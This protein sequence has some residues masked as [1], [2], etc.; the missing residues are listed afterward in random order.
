MTLPDSIKKAP[1]NWYNLD[2][3]K[4]GVIGVSTEKAYNELLRGKKPSKV[5][6]AIIDSGIETDHEDLKGSIWTNSDEIPANGIDDDN[7]G[8][9]DDINGWDFIGGPDSTFVEQDTWE[10]TRQYVIFSNKYELKDGESLINKDL[11]DWDYFQT[12]KTDYD[13]QYAENKDSYDNIVFLRDKINSSEAILKAYL[14]TDTVLTEDLLN[15]KTEVD[16]VEE[17]CVFLK[18]TRN[19]GINVSHLEGG[20]KYYETNLK[21]KLNK[22]F[23]PRHIVGDDYDDLTSHHYGNNLVEGPDAFHGTHVSGIVCADRENGIGIKGIADA[24][25]LM[26]LRVVPSGDERDKDVA[27]AVFY[28]VDNGAKIINMSFGKDYS[29]YK[30]YVDSAFR[31]ADAHGVLVIHAAGNDSK[32]SD[33]SPSYPTKKYLD[34]KGVCNNWIEVGAIH[35]KDGNNMAAGFTNYGKNTVDLFAPGVEIYSTMPNQGY[36]NASG[37][38]MAAPVVTGVAALVLSYHPNL[39][40]AEL[41]KVL[42]DSA[43]SY[44]RQKVKKPGNP[45]ELVRFAKLSKTGSVVNA[46]TALKAADKFK[47]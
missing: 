31:Y 25:E 19:Q 21:Y 30:F 35:W 5:V 17:A 22:E 16:S 33:I 28:A 14:K 11:N 36:R 4:D 3:S 45:E 13:N 6:V 29:P 24:V 37:T 15:L 8:Y 20:I 7:N 12:L 1:A 44:K 27:N 34:G 46:Y 2:A 40:A 18:K 9:V 10:L 47:K 43:V 26:V 39:T 38:S 32:N 42:L 23:D 41:K